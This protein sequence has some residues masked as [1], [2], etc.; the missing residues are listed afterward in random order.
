MR[1]TNCVGMQRIFVFGSNTAG[2]HGAG[3]ARAAV[4]LH[5]AA[6]GVGVGR[7]GNAYAIPTVDERI[8]PLPLGDIGEHIA[9]F[10][11]YARGHA[12]IAFDVVAIGCGIAGFVPAQ[13]AP[14]FADA[15]VN[16]VLPLGWRE[17]GRRVW[18]AAR[19]AREV[20]RAYC[21]AIGDMTQLTWAHAPR[22]QQAS[23]IEGVRGI[24]E[25]TITGPGDAHRSW[26]AQKRADGWVWGP[27][28]DADARTHPCM[29]P[30]DQL[31]L[32]QQVKDHLFVATVQTALAVLRAA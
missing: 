27:V 5:G 28:K 4:D 13:M 24:L 15:P 9:T 11:A 23:A 10:V 30:F 12:H 1:E 19:L 14:W 22:W 29:V 16:V 32:E 31:P 6:M 17:L 2:A 3:S 7:T 20:N 18:D 25:E 21:A 8:T 26:C